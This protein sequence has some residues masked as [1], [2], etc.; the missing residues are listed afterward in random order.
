MSQDILFFAQTNEMI[1]FVWAKNGKIKFVFSFSVMKLYFVI[2]VLNN[3]TITD[4]ANSCEISPDF[5]ELRL[6]I[7]QAIFRA[8]SH[9]G[10]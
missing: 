1:S 9:D 10:G 4:P 8:I 7:S 2:N 5:S 3:K 6:T